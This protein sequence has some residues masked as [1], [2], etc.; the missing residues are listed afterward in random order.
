MLIPQAEPRNKE[1]KKGLLEER[2]EYDES[3]YKMTN[4]VY[5]D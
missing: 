3:K 2:H 4:Y 1:G 5:H